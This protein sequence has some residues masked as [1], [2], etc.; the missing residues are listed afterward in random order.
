VKVVKNVSL[1]GKWDKWAES[2]SRGIT[3]EWDI[4]NCGG[5]DVKRRRGG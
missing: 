2:G 5:G 1:K 4:V 3:K